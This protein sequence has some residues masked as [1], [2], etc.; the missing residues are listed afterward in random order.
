MGST[1]L[2]VD[3]YTSLTLEGIETSVFI[4]ADDDASLVSVEYW[5][6]I[7]ENVILSLYQ[8]DSSS[9]ISDSSI[10]REYAD[11]VGITFSK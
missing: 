6:D 9:I 8:T 7:L 2:S 4:G 3:T 1:T 5:E 11:S 10:I